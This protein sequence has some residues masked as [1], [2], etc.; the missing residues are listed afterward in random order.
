[1]AGI[2]AALGYKVEI[3][4]PEKVSEETKKILR[5][6]GAI[7]H[8]TSDDLCLR[9]GAGTDQSI[10]LAKAISKP[11]PDIYYMLIQHD[12]NTISCY[13][14]RLLALRCGGRQ[15]ESSL[16]LLQAAEQEAQ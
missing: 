8:E 13:T 15:I 11:R 14:M 1:L 7:I 16:I 4:I 12:N 2:S 3:V 5:N 6:L 10:A 9:V